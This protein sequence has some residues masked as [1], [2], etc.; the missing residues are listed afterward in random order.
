MRPMLS[1]SRP[2]CTNQL[3]RFDY[4]DQPADRQGIPG[5]HRW[6]KMVKSG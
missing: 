4:H 3:H 2:G 5:L 1:L 6:V